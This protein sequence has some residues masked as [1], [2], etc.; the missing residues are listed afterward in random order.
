MTAELEFL[1]VA[2]RRMNGV[3]VPGSMMVAMRDEGRKM[4]TDGD[5][6]VELVR[7]EEKSQSKLSGDGETASVSSTTPGQHIEVSRT[8]LAED[9]RMGTVLRLILASFILLLSHHI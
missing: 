7:D 8:D 5:V 6:E 4:Q 2:R 3:K 1:R 9:L